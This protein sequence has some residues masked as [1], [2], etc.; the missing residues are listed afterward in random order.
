MQKTA[1]EM[2]IS[3]WSSD[4][5]SSDLLALE[6]QAE[7]RIGKRAQR[8]VAADRIGAHRAMD[9]RARQADVERAITRLRIGLG[10]PVAIEQMEPRAGAEPLAHIVSVGEAELP[11]RDET[12]LHVIEPAIDEARRGG[13][14][15]EIG[16]RKSTRL[17]SSH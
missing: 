4:V 1:Y 9:E 2:R 11:F 15:G 6:H 12:Q 17:N 7:R 16:D 10:R 13:R 8:S 5:C 14:A 3:D